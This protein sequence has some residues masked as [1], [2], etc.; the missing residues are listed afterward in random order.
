M[1]YGVKKGDELYYVGYGYYKVLDVKMGFD[2]F[3]TIQIIELG[4]SKRKRFFNLDGYEVDTTT[5]RPISKQPVLLWEE[6]K[7][8]IP[9]K[10]KYI[11]KRLLK[12]FEDIPLTKFNVGDIVIDVLMN[13]V[14]KVTH[15]YQ[16][17]TI[18]VTFY[19]Y[20]KEEIKPYDK[21]GYR[22]GLRVLFKEA[23]INKHIV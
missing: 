19:Q 8:R 14:G 20:N 9:D 22:S 4:V 1:L 17:G 12:K 18:V 5:W 21:D 23:D 7:Y 15:I 11:E 6:V 3:T 13:K 2:G 10:P 16:D